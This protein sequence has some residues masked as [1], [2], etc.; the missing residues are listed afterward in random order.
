M[1][2]NKQYIKERLR[3]YKYTCIKHLRNN[4]WAENPSYQWYQKDLK[5]EMFKK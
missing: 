5:R 4:F 2:T 1:T 3:R